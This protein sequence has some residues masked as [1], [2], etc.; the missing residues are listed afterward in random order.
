MK[1]ICITTVI[2]FIFHGATADLPPI[3]AAPKGD[4]KSVSEGESINAAHSGG[5]A[6]SSDEVT[7]MVTE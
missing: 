5:A 2:F 3:G 4:A 1:R 7:V 6:R